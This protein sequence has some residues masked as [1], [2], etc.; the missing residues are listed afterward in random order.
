MAGLIPFNRRNAELART[1]TGFEDF[2]NMLD[3]FFSDNWL[4]GRNLSKD[5]FKIDISEADDGYHIEAELPGVKKEE[6]S[7]GIE[8]ENLLISVNRAEETNDE[9]K[10][11]IH[12]E[13]RT[14][15]MSRRIRLAGA[16]PDSI[17]AKLED[18]VLNITIPKSE[19]V[20][21]TRTIEIE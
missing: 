11:F 12:R 1:G 7:L 17:T 20:N 21:T 9:G 4:S 6:I 8:D 10:N 15:S 2:Y 14:S 13:R 16:D 19:P 5:T 3:D 18:G